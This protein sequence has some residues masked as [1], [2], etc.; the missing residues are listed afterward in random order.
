ME[1]RTPEDRDVHHKGIDFAF[2]AVYHPAAYAGTHVLEQFWT[3]QLAKSG[4]AYS[5][6]RHERDVANLTRQFSRLSIHDVNT[7]NVFPIAR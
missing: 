1:A 2:N 5:K 7:T 3:I 6:A 4:L